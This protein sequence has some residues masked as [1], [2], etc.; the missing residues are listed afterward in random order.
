MNKE[1]LEKRIGELKNANLITEK[2]ILQAQVRSHMNSGA[3][4]MCEEML[5]SFEVARS[6]GEVVNMIGEIKDI[7]VI[8]KVLGI[9]EKAKVRVRASVKKSK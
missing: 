7:E 5:K 4:A 6:A 9:K 1:Q 2:Q 3:I 8:E